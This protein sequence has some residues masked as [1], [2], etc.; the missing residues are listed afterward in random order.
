LK[1]FSFDSGELPAGSPV[2]LAFGLA[3]GGKIALDAPESGAGTITG[4]APFDPRAVGTP[5]TL[6]ATLTPSELIKLPL[7]TL[8]GVP[9]ITGD[10]ELKLIGGTV[11]STFTTTCT[12]GGKASGTLSTSGTAAAKIAAPRTTLRFG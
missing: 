6:T 2:Q 3:A 10:L 7:A 12:D 8:L 11:S 5:A 1:G 9:A 4:S